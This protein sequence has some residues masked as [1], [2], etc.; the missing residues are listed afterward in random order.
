MDG[1]W[2]F[3]LGNQGLLHSAG[4]LWPDDLKSLGLPIAVASPFMVH[5]RGFQPAI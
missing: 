2:V 3:Q 5:F 1:F 4:R